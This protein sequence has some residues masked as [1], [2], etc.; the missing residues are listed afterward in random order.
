M[1][2]FIFKAVSSIV[3][4][5]FI[6]SNFTP[7]FLQTKVSGEGRAGFTL[8]PQVY[9]QPKQNLRVEQRIEGQGGDV[10]S[11]FA[12]DAQAAVSSLGRPVTDVGDRHRD[13]NVSE[14]G[15]DR[16]HKS[17][18]R[19]P[20]KAP[21]PVA[22]AGPFSIATVT[23][24]RTTALGS[25]TL[26]IDTTLAG[27]GKG[28]FVVAAGT[29]SGSEE[30]KTILNPKLS[31][32]NYPAAFA[33]VAEI[34]RAVRAAGLSAN[35]LPEMGKLM[36]GLGKERL[37]AEP[38][39]GYQMAAAWAV[40]DQRKIGLYEL[41]GG[42][43]VGIPGTKIQ[44]N[45][46]NGGEHAKNDLDI[47]EFMVVPIGA[48]V[49]EANQMC[50][51]IDRELGLIYQQLGLKAD[52]NDKG[53]GNLRGKEGGYKVEDLTREKL[54]EIYTNTNQYIIKN[55]L[56]LRNLK[57]AELRDGKIGIHEFV[58]NCLIAAVKNAGYEVSK[59]GKPGTVSLA[60]DLAATSMLVE[61]RIDL[62]NYEGRQITSKELV[63]IVI[64][65]TKKYAIDSIE[66]I[67]GEED[68]DNWMYA[69]EQMPDDVMLIP[70]D[71]T[72]SQASRIMKLIKMLEA[73]G[74]IKDHRAIKRIGI[75]IKLNQNG[76]LTTGITNPDEGYLGTLEVMSLNDSY[77]IA[78]VVSHRSKEADAKEHEVSIADL[79]AG[80]R[81]YALKSGNF[82][83]TSVRA[84]KER[85]LAAID[86]F[87]RMKLARAQFAALPPAP[88]LT[89]EGLKDAAR[90]QM[91]PDGKM[92]GEYGVPPAP[93]A[94]VATPAL[95]PDATPS[96]VDK[97]IRAMIRANGW[98]PA[99]S[100][101]KPL[102]VVYKRETLTGI[103]HFVDV[104]VILTTDYSDVH[105]ASDATFI[106]VIISAIPS[107]GISKISSVVS[108]RQDVPKQVKDAFASLV[109]PAGRAPKLTR[110][111]LK[112]DT[113][114]DYQ[115]PGSPLRSVPSA[116]AVAP[117]R[118]IDP[119][120]GTYVHQERF[121][122]AA[123][124]LAKIAPYTDM[125]A[126]AQGNI[127]L[128]VRAD[129]KEEFRPV[130]ADLAYD[131]VLHHDKD[132]QAAAQWLIKEL[133]ASYGV[134]SASIRDY[135]K[136]MGRREINGH[137]LPA[138]N[139][140][141]G[142][143][144]TARAAF[145]AA[146]KKDIGAVEFELAAS[147]ATYTGRSYAGYAAEVLA[148][149]V[150]EGH[151]MPVF[152]K[153]DHTQINAKKYKE[154]PEKE[155]ARIKSIIEEGLRAGFRNIDI[156]A[157][158][159]EGKPV[160]LT[161]ADVS[162]S[163]E[164]AKQQYKL[165]KQQ[166][167]ENI[168]VS[169]MLISFARDKAREIQGDSN[170]AIGVEVGEVGK[171]NTTLTQVKACLQGILK[172][173]ES[174]G[175]GRT[176]YGPDVIS[177]QTGA[178]HG[179][180][181][182][183]VTG[184]LVRDVPIAFDILKAVS[185]LVRSAEYGY[186]AGSVQHGAST[187]EE[188]K[189]PYF[190]ENDVAEV[191]LATEYQSLAL[192]HDALPAGLI[193]KIA[194]VGEVLF[195]RDLKAWEEKEGKKADDK[196]KAKIRKDSVK[197]LVGQAGVTQLFW[198]LP[199]DAEAAVSATLEGKFIR[200]FTALGA[201]NTKA[202][203]QPSVEKQ[204]PAPAAPA[205]IIQSAQPTLAAATA[206]PPTRENLRAA[207]R[208]NYK[209]QFGIPSAPAGQGAVVGQA[210][211]P[212]VSIDTYDGYIVDTSITYTVSKPVVDADGNT[213]ATITVDGGEGLG[214]L[215]GRVQLLRPARETAEVSGTAHL[216]PIVEII[217]QQAPGGLAK[218]SGTDL[219]AQISSA[220]NVPNAQP[221]DLT[222]FAGQRA[223]GGLPLAQATTTSGA[224]VATPASA[225]AAPAVKGPSY[226]KI[227]EDFN[228]PDYQN[229]L[230]NAGLAGL[231]NRQIELIISSESLG[232]LNGSPMI[233]KLITAL[234]DSGIE[235]SIDKSK[236]IA[237]LSRVYLISSGQIAAFKKTDKED[238]VLAIQSLTDKK[239]AAQFY[240]ALLAGLAFGNIT[241][242]EV[243][244]ALKGET[245][246]ITKA[247]AVV[248]LYNSLN[249]A[250]RLNLAGLAI[251]VNPD[252]EIGSLRAILSQI[253]ANLPVPV[254][255]KGEDLKMTL[256]AIV[257]A[258]SKV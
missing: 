175:H 91:T 13:P 186:M 131:A 96:V 207:T 31:D 213:I 115:K 16:R 28:H 219:R 190:P 32:S 24:S 17:G 27:G 58:L 234:R 114:F 223:V 136:A 54:T 38:I 129:K 69:F 51:R 121:A 74:L 109:P 153:M 26:R 145:R 127:H 92:P 210:T 221:L 257:E 198:N 25:P 230:Y 209:D 46:T 187:L 212:T 1:K 226:G 97:A 202:L 250:I 61:G 59:S 106:T 117:V 185:N 5:C 249:P 151:D 173:L 98:E 148:A 4:F 205:N 3:V 128:K 192:K 52:P 123:E 140:R 244:A 43:D 53:V 57:I 99:E 225:T 134:Y 256:D 14:P 217:G 89:R 66:D 254:P 196:T 166:Q 21:A 71:L 159:L 252:T 93:K 80:R 160:L 85:R 150:M 233:S 35:Q 132:A 170:I 95:S 108:L 19:A 105:G 33:S 189:F 11:S 49:A 20:V 110:E 165:D 65:W 235:V 135:Y 63:D 48:T 197:K 206:V 142:G 119:A 77:D 23:P 42:T 116:P 84:P 101:S 231:K 211:V 174:Y 237:G 156:D 139:V 200:L 155:I 37:G 184:Q 103:D 30:A 229:L 193:A 9:A 62:Y 243:Q 242:D 224:S 232:V 36:L 112:K 56:T 104:Q 41:I 164:R 169:A 240:K 163:A 143:L 162:D 168:R 195:Q 241:S 178:E 111:G 146:K 228:S 253:V 67:L 22:A 158:T 214:N 227:L 79:A 50:D 126:D 238:K 120:T 138:N 167:Q 55:G 73:R 194:E 70:D 251:L 182:D 40:A 6:F 124:M 18:R 176:T 246:A 144:L 102:Q 157:S 218:M 113:K 78:N 34:D 248:G 191:H 75:L 122:S 94:P 154:D 181:N 45:I 107:V 239:Q 220:L 29:S 222:R 161:E 216:E 245:K 255:T 199:T 172:N 152:L 125:S 10:G 82:V 12:R 88:K 147:E 149:A 87:E 204:T 180:R 7:P 201:D 177:I 130:F 15:R 72:V 81:A 83:Q 203:I 8:A 188:D 208:H 118:L 137:T 44:Y 141:V 133:A 215:T 68:W 39:L 90:G 183:P 179:G 100:G 64:A 47:Q 247:D 236:N 60:F 86:K 258:L 171:E 76:F 2:R